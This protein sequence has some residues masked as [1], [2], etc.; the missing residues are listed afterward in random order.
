MDQRK[1]DG[2][3]GASSMPEWLS[4]AGSTKRA[5]APKPHKRAAGSSSS[6]QSMNTE[7]WRR[8]TE[9]ERR[10]AKP[11]ASAESRKA[12]EEP[13][14]A[15][16][17]AFKS[18]ARGAARGAAKASARAASAARTAKR[19]ASSAAADAARRKGPS[20]IGRDAKGVAPA[21]ARPS[22]SR[23]SAEGLSRRGTKA[24]AGIA[25][26]C[27]VAAVLFGCWWTL[28]RSVSVTVNGQPVTARVG[29]TLAALVKDNGNFGVTPGKLMSLTGQIIDGQG[30]DSYEVKVGG[31]QV[32]R[33]QLDKTKLGGGEAITVENGADVTEDHDEQTVD[34][35][36][37]LEMQKGGSIQYVSQW[38]RAGKKVVWKG[39]VSGEQVDHQVIDQA[40]NMVVA[41]RTPQ[42]QDGGKYM[43]LTF[44]DGPSRYTPQILQILK[45]KGVH[46]T[47]FNLGQQASEFGDY[48]KQVVA[49]G[50]ELASH[51][52][53]HKY[54]PKLDRD[55][56]RAEVTLA[57]D[58]LE[59]VSGSRPQM[60]RAP[61]GAFTGNCWLRTNDLIS[62][63]VLWNIDTLD[64]KRPGADA[65]KNMVLSNA[66]N[67][68]IALMHDGGGDRTQDIEALPGIIDGLQQAGYKLVTVQELMR[69]DGTFPKDVVNGTVKQ[70]KDA[71]LPS[72][73]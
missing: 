8:I 22:G 55:A 2:F 6:V 24:A 45:D 40:V 66:Y 38:G 47:F 28:W 43:A 4:G 58:T 13:S 26:V 23:P 60:I 65:I 52:N 20:A 16:S 61:Y 3:K 70:P 68:A 63:N 56:L 62:C 53:A 73:S 7:S 27:I 36:P 35:P 51:T 10:A 17:D 33:D 1:Q 49:D 31:E 15:W 34:V 14:S 46:A 9:G 67:G 57:A 39:K 29:T 42:P 69:L 41:S 5:K 72:E 54:L 44:D 59:R 30:G 12:T 11:S 71:A 25:A 37:A 18:A 64:W 19:A 32:P 50:N 48:S 21:S